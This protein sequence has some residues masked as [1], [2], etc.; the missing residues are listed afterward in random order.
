MAQQFFWFL[1]TVDVVLSIGLVLRRH[2]RGARHLNT[3]RAAALANS[4]HKDTWIA[5]AVIWVVLMSKGYS[6]GRLIC[7][8]GIAIL[9]WLIQR[10]VRR[11]QSIR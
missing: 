9:A 8:A 2:A 6:I 11:F 3:P 1:A 4:Q 5:C 10:T 7:V